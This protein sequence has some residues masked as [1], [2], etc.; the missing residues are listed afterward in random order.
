[1]MSEQQWDSANSWPPL[2]HMVIEGFRTA[3]S[4]LP[5]HPDSPVMDGRWTGDPEMYEVALDLAN[6][7]LH[8]SHTSFKTTSHM[9]EKYNA[10]SESD[11]A[12]GEGSSLSPALGEGVMNGVDVGRR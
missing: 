12:H 6:R 3:G 10:S 2:V 7:W 8:I 4:C 1:M 5:P 9:Y 11:A